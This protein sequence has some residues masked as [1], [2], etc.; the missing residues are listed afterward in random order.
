[1]LEFAE[2]V[3]NH[4]E[5]YWDSYYRKKNEVN[6]KPF[7]SQF[8]VFSLSEMKARGISHVYEIG[9]GDGRDAL[10]FAE[11]GQTV[12]ASDKSE[13]AI[14]LL[15]NHCRMHS[16]IK[17]MQHDVDESLAKI[18]I[19]PERPIAIYARFLLHALERDKMERFLEACSLVM[20]S[21]DS[22][23][24]EYRTDKDCL[25]PKVTEPHFREFYDPKMIVGKAKEF[26]LKIDYQV[27]GKGFAKWKGDDA[28]VARQ[29]FVKSNLKSAE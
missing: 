12:I 20:D 5:S 21:G 3:Q 16:G 8:A 1:M 11:F 13:A 6:E 19:Q 17:A 4:D 28:Y 29:I 24:L 18:V 26:M 14:S 15:E 25:L 10:F 23:F 27:E 7:P 2:E 22:L 9:S